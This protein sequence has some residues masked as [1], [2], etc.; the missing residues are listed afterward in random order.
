MEKQ[1]YIS[2]RQLIVLL[3]MT[4][5]TFSMSY[6]VSLSAG[7]S[8]Q[9]VLLAVPVNFILNYIVA[10]PI[11]IL[12]KRHP[13]KD[14]VELAHNIL[15]RA[16][17]IFIAVFYMLCFVFLAIYLLATFHNYYVNFILP[18]SMYYAIAIPLLIV[19]F[20]G[21]VKGIETIARFGSIVIIL[22]LIIVAVIGLSLIPQINF[23]F[24]FPMLY[25]GPK[26]F[27]GAVLS[28]VNSNLQIVFLAF[29]AP[30]LKLGTK[31]GKIYTKWNVIAMLLF[32]MLEFLTVT[33]MGPFAAKQNFPLP[34][35]ALLSQVGVFERL[36]A[37]DMISWILNTVLSVTFYVYIATVCLLKTGLNKHRKIITFLIVTVV[38]AVA[39]FVTP[40]FT[41]LHIITINPLMTVGTLTAIILL[42][43]TILLADLIKGRVA[44]NEKAA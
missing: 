26:V 33:V 32:L 22:Y 16:A 21:A 8:I 39:Y 42:P 38:F 30:F 15:G 23:D 2:S 9:D 43:F 4:K 29:C 17:G 35:L 13:G 5:L 11:L 40:F 41:V 36:D 6:Y 31:L 1:S 20:Y 27:L 12:L 3:I 10:I 14:L 34:E 24:L 25:N 37:V 44:S 28:G 18:E 19:A 7:R